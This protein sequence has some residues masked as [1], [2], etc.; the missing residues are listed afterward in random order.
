MPSDIAFAS[1]AFNAKPDAVNIWIGGVKS[2]SSLHR[3]PYENVYTVI[4]G[5]KIFKLFPP[6]GRSKILYREFDVVRCHYDSG[7]W[8]RLPEPG[9][10]SVKW[11]EHGADGVDLE[12]MIVELHPGETLYLPAGWFH[13]V[14]Q[15]D[16]TIAVN[17][18]YDR[19]Y[20]QH[21]TKEKFIDQL[22]ELIHD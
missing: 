6:T 8:T 4:S 18:W 15:I 16:C 2:I 1:C 9:I 13:Q 19:S 22:V 12:P 20:D 3:D 11:I 17:Y 10:E 5:K 7:K 21:Y 14:H